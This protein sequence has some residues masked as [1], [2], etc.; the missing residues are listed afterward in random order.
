MRKRSQARELALKALYQWHQR[1]DLTLQDMALFCGGSSRHAD[2]SEFALSLVQGVAERAPELDD[3][4]AEVA[5]HWALDR[6]AVIDRV[7]LRMGVYQLLYRDDIPP[8]VAINESIDLAKRYSQE[9]SGQ[10]VN[11]ILDRVYADLRCAQST[12]EAE[13]DAG[14]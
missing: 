14:S 9:H 2:V 11:G 3:R 1:D 7:V 5:E 8:K 13:G 4:I 6:M 12:A 10:F